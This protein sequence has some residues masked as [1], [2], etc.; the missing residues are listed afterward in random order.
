MSKSLNSEEIIRG[1]SLDSRIGDHYNNPSFGYGGY[2][3]PKDNKKLLSNFEDIPQDL[4]KSVLSSNAKRKG[5]IANKIF[6]TYCKTF[7]FYKL[8]M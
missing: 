5:Y 6:Y 3:L 7:L 4:I 2:C 8:V 1:L